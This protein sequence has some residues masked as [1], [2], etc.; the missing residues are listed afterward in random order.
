MATRTNSIGCGLIAGV[1]LLFVLP[2][3]YVL[4]VQRFRKPSEYRFSFPAT[5]QLTEQDALALSRR[6]MILNGKHTD[7]MRP[8]PSGHK[9]VNGRDVYFCRKA[10]KADEGW[11]LWWLA[12]P[13]HAWEY[14][15]GITRDGDEVVCTICNPL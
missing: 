5:R 13:D 7:A 9:D 10:G 12:R 14:S 3:V 2:L 4:A 11:V 8:V 15:V 1:V 6:A